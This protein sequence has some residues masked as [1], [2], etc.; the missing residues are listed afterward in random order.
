VLGGRASLILV[1][2]Y[3]QSSPGQVRHLVAL[4]MFG[5]SHDLIGLANDCVKPQASGPQGPRWSNRSTTIAASI[6]IIPRKKIRHPRDVR[7]LP[8]SR[9]FHRAAL[10]G[11]RDR[12]ASSGCWRH[13]EMKSVREAYVWGT[14][15]SDV[16]SLHMTCGARFAHQGFR[17]VTPARHRDPAL[18]P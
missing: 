15:I 11:R 5:R 17:Y 2:G 9:D 12:R 10:F 16:R 4:R 14:G 13:T 1:E 18:Q 6:R 7:I 3:I 8:P